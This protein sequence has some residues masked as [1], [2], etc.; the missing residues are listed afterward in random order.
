MRLQTRLDKLAWVDYS[1]RGPTTD[2]DPAAQ[3]RHALLTRDGPRAAALLDSGVDPRSVDAEGA[4]FL[5][6]AALGGDPALVRLLLQRGADPDQASRLGRT[7][8]GEAAYAG[9]AAAAAVLLEAGASPDGAPGGARPIVEAG[10][11]GATDAMRVLVEHGCDLHVADPGDRQTPLA[12]AARA[13]DVDL[14][15]RMLQ[16]GADPRRAD[17]HGKSPLMV[18]ANHGHVEVVRALLDAGAPVDAA[19]PAGGTALWWAPKSRADVVRLLLERGARADV[20]GANARTPISDA[21]SV[22]NLEVFDRLLAAGARIDVGLGALAEA[23]RHGHVAL[24]RRILGLDGVDVDRADPHPC[25]GRTPL[26][27]AAEG[28]S[29]EGVTLVLERGADPRR[30][31]GR[32]RTALHAAA[33]YAHAGVVRILVAS[34][35][36]AESRDALGMTPLILAASNR[37]VWLEERRRLEVVRVLLG[38]AVDRDAPDRQ[39]WTPLH[40]AAS[41]AFAAIVRLLLEAGADP[42]AED[43]EGRTPL[44]LAVGFA[45]HDYDTRQPV[46]PARESED[47][48]APVV[49]LL[50]GRA[51]R[52]GL[53][54]RRRRALAAEAKRHR[55]PEIVAEFEALRA[56]RR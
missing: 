53:P 18:A 7:P 29:E 43:G 41:D 40:H 12:L 51:L 13:G 9:R 48:L 10:R 33:A 25:P 24:A 20:V 22:G 44:A 3:L 6:D 16:R 55:C 11:R 34:G 28:G 4:G 27:A 15:R 35:A 36:E 5:H 38:A 17:L 50:L 49:R 23:L 54:A 31:D 8:L 56:R 2:H 37:A 14:V 1:Y 42:A 39:G 21:A 45:L 30:R 52:D 32:G 47:P 26:I 46:Q 19:D